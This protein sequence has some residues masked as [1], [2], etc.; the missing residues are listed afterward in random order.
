VRRSTLLGRPL[1][2]S[3]AIVRVL[4]ARSLWA[5]VPA[6]IVLAPT[7]ADAQTATTGVIT[8]TVVDNVTKR[9]MGDVV[10]EVSGATGEQVVVTDASGG[11]RV[12]NL[13]PGPYTVRVSNEGYKPSGTSVT[14]NANATIRVNVSM[15]PTTMTAA[16][17]V[18]VGK[19]PTV[20]VG[21]AQTGLVLTKEFTNRIAVARPTAKGGA[22]RSFESIAEIAPGAKA[23]DY[24][25]SINGTTSP[26]NRYIVDGLAVNNPA[27]GINGTP[28]SIEFVKEVNVIAGGYMPEFGRSTGGVLNVVTESGTNEF[29]GSA[30]VNFSPGAIE[31]ERKRF[32]PAGQTIRTDR[33]V[34]LIHDFGV[35]LGGPILK[36]KLFFFGGL[37][38]NSTRWRNEQNLYRRT[39]DPNKPLFNPDGT[40]IGGTNGFDFATDENGDPIT[41]IVPGTRDVRPA[42]QRGI[43][44]MAKL[45]FQANA[46][47][48]LELSVFGA[49][50]NSGGDGTWGINPDSG[51]IQGGANDYAA[52]AHRFVAE[53]NGVNLKWSSAFDN[54]TFLIDANIGWHRQ[55]AARLPSDGSTIGSKEGLAGRPSVLWQKFVPIHND[56]KTFRNTPL[57]ANG[58]PY[59]QDG[60]PDAYYPD[61]DPAN[62]DD[63]STSPF[64]GDG[65][66]DNDLIEAPRDPQ[67]PAVQY[68][69]GGPDF[70]NQQDMDRVH[71]KIILTKL[72]KAL[73]T[74]VVKGGIDFEQMSYNHTKAYSG[75]VRYAEN[76]SGSAFNQQRRY[77]F[78]TGPDTAVVQDLQR[79]S[80]NSTQIGAFVQDSWSLL[81]KVTLNLGV[82]WD[83][84]FLFGDDGKVGMSLPYQFAPRVGIIYDITQSGR[85]KIFANFARYFE[86][87]P[88]NLVDR[89]FPG[90]SQIGA[91]HRAALCD[92][93]GRDPMRDCN[94]P[95]SLASRG[96]VFGTSFDPNQ[97][98]FSTGASKV[99]VDPNLQ[100][101][102]S[103]EIVVGGEYEVFP[104]G[105]VGAQYTHRYMVN[106]IEDMSRDEATTYFIGNPGSGIAKDFPSASRD[107]D[108]VNIYF[109]KNFSDKWLAQ[110]S[111]TL[112]FLRGN[113]AGL[114]RPETGQLDPN[115]NSDFDLQS[116]TVNRYGALPGDRTHEIKVYAARDF[117]FNEFVAGPANMQLNLGL[118]YNGRSGGPTSFLAAHPIYGGSE[119]MIL[120]RGTGDR[121]PWTHGIDTHVQYDL[122]LSKNAQL[123]VY[124]DIFNMFNFQETTA[125]DEDYSFG[126]IA[127][128]VDGKPVKNADGKLE[129][130]PAQLK[131][132]DGTPFDVESGRNP[133]FGR[134]LAFQSPRQ[135]RFGAKVTF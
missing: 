76:G 23:D 111:Y 91:R 59:C 9:G 30:W 53:T 58:Q 67:C 71:G 35:K 12:P 40:A 109:T 75:T 54:K 5:V 72:F 7:A 103:D 52:T 112:S 116:L 128:I 27:Y 55:K 28:L 97:F 92:P 123:S 66:P 21:S 84:Q 86:A 78:L 13:A 70:I 39:L 127:P 47:N 96:R 115:I 56:L 90:E 89:A 20:D 131:N 110:V 74:H 104:D 26:E 80:S 120:P 69:S 130:D 49:P 57:D 101:Q 132:P 106:V 46:D 79:A 62:D 119:V 33:N 42:V 99:P 73:G 129:P 85:S 10:V 61:P 41:E 8:G 31:G 133:N 2:R 108:G 95:A 118:G 4:L 43:Q 121:L 45:T 22:A 114:Y 50:S 135:F 126:E 34:D 29:H 77:G 64:G 17:T 81:D 117:P 18:V 3:G 65:V 36:D 93:T 100:P 113:I 51:A 125:I 14:L 134:P 88:L 1:G 94:D 87:I 38:F 102:A 48:T 107:Y 11:Y 25:V 37:S 60:L 122:K 82:R 63:G 83:S 44:Y 6:A 105:R 68:F 124:M 19:A 16:E 98:W 24:G 15:T 32:L